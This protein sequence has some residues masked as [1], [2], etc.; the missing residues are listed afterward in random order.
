[1]F[2]RTVIEF[3]MVWL[4]PKP[5]ILGFWKTGICLLNDTFAV[6]FYLYLL[7]LETGMI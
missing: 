7:I 4:N 3:D 1:M 5:C 2:L 6:I